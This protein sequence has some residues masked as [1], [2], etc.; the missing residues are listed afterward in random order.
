MGDEKPTEQTQPPQQPIETTEQ[1]LKVLEKTQEKMFSLLVWGFGTLSLLAFAL[2]GGNIWT[3]HSNYERDNENLTKD[4]ELLQK[5]L[6]LA[7]Q[8]LTASNDKKLFEL[9][10]ETEASFITTSNNLQAQLNTIIQSNDS[11]WFH[12]AEAITNKSEIVKSNLL[13]LDSNIRFEFL[14]FVTNNVTNLDDEIN[15]QLATVQTNV[16]K[17]TAAAFAGTLLVEANSLPKNT[18]GEKQYAFRDYILSAIYFLRAE[19]ED[20]AS[21]A[22]KNLL[23]KNAF[24]NYLFRFTKQVYKAQETE[25]PIHKELEE[26]IKQLKLLNSNGRYAE[27][28]KVF[29]Y[30]DDA[31]TDVLSK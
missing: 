19:D 7:Q 17:L 1:R 21:R 20:N 3:S 9:K 27:E 29:Q 25:Y 30:C 11:K 18:L 8:D 31:I 10:T 5:Q 28:L 2:V 4:V 12:I 16:N 6:A 22:M 24:Q 23:T 14:E 13:A 26:L 15:G